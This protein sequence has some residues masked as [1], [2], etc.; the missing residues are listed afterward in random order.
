MAS[1]LHEMLNANRNRHGKS[2]VIHL[3]ITLLDENH[4]KPQ[5]FHHKNQSF[6]HLIKF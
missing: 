4:I 5:M 1:L 6:Q 3:A 2:S